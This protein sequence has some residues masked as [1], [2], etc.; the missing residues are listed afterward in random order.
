MSNIS[1]YKNDTIQK[2]YFLFLE[3]GQY[4]N[5]V[6]KIKLRI[7]FDFQKLSLF[8]GEHSS[9][10]V[11]VK[12]IHH[13]NLS[14][15]SRHKIYSLLLLGEKFSHEFLNIRGTELFIRPCFGSFE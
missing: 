7:E 10:N 1:R 15:K 13:V 4:F 2:V 3:N 11:L 6:A 14:A 12:S 5:P 8:V 9:L